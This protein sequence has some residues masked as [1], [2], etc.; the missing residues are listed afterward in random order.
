MREISNPASIIY[1]LD[2]DD[3]AMIVKALGDLSIKLEDGGSDKDSARAWDVR[4]A[5]KAAMEGNATVRIEV[6]A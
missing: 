5:V 6:G 1:M 3:A 4:Q 2:A